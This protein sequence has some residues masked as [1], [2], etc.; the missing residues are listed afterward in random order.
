MAVVAVIVA[1]WVG[2]VRTVVGARSSTSRS[3]IIVIV[4]IAW[5]PN[6]VGRSWGQACP[7]SLRLEFRLSSGVPGVAVSS[8]TSR[9]VRRPV[10]LALPPRHWGLTRVSLCPDSVRAAARAGGGRVSTIV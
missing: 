5:V 1:A 4:Y 7:R 8:L 10:P 9:D 6:G 3:S 2:E